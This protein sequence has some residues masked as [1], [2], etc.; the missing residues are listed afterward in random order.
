MD[1]YDRDA[2]NQ[3]ALNNPQPGD[4]WNEM[5]CPYFIVVDVKGNR[6]T[7]LS[8]M[9]GPDSWDRKDEPNAK[10]DMKDGWGL[11]Y[12][13]SMIVDRA[14]IERAV[15][16]KDFDGFVAD[17]VRSKKTIAIVDEWRDWKQKQMRHQIEKLEAEWEEFTGWRHLKETVSE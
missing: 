11:D 17:V 7:V 14:W 1:N 16:Y 12:S 10:I 13:K 5:F 9:G 8:C 4:Y 15:K 6:Y 2:E 3:R